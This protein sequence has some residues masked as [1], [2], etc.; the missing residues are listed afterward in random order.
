MSRAPYPVV[1]I[2]GLWLHPISWSPWAERFRAAGYDP[3]TPGW[4]GDSDTVEETRR[5]PERLAGLGIDEVTGHFAGICDACAEKPIVVGHSFGGL[6][7]QK[8]LGEGHAAAAVAIS[9]AQ[10]RGVLPLPLAQLRSALPVLANPLNYRRVVSQTPDQFYWGFANTV[11]RS[12]A[13]SLHARYSIPAPGRPL[14]EAAF[15]NLNP[16]T[17]ARVQTLNPDRGPLLIIGGGRDRTVPELV[18]R[19]SHRQYRKAVTENDYRMFEDRGHSMVIDF[20]WSEVAD[21]ALA[22]LKAHGL[23]STG[24]SSRSVLSLETKSRSRASARKQI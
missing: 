12:E 8:L 19:A 16:S 6:I 4:P 5:H 3:S 15:A 14:F 24:R 22:W 21:A 11:S 18:S 17:A 2:H 13:Y 20:G 23:L 9:P 7:A 1:F 10:M